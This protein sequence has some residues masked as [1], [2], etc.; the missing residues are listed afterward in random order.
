MM[1]EMEKNKFSLSTQRRHEINNEANEDDE[2]PRA[3]IMKIE[4]FTNEGREIQLTQ[5]TSTLQMTQIVRLITLRMINNSV[6]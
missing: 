1:T 3:S 5:A 6:C 4:D 2:K